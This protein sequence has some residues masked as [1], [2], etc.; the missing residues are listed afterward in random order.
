MA[1]FIGG[2]SSRTTLSLVCW[3]WIRVAKRFVC[4][5]L[6]DVAVSLLYQWTA[7]WIT[8]LKKLVQVLATVWEAICQRK[9]GNRTEHRCCGSGRAMSNI[10][11]HYLGKRRVVWDVHLR[12]GRSSSFLAIYRIPVPILVKALSSKVKPFR[13]RFQCDQRG[14]TSSMRVSWTCFPLHKTPQL[15]F[16]KCFLWQT[17]HCLTGMFSHFRNCCRTAALRPSWVH[18]WLTRIYVFSNKLQMYIGST[19]TVLTKSSSQ[20]LSGPLAER[21]TEQDLVKHL[22]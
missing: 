19:S 13:W 17:T 7:Y 9:T 6:R 1:L 5:W 8:L 10:N 18:I 12:T 21:G 20:T 3:M 14:H 16:G 11:V 22:V 15:V 2:K 4:K